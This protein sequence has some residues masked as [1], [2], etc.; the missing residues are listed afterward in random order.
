MFDWL[1]RNQPSMKERL[2][3]LSPGLKLEQLLDSEVSPGPGSL[4]EVEDSEPTYV[5]TIRQLLIDLPS[6]YPRL[7]GT[8]FHEKAEREYQVALRIQTN[9]NLRQLAV[10]EKQ[11]SLRQMDSLQGK[12]HVMEPGQI[13]RP[14]VPQ[15]Q[16]ES[17]ISAGSLG[18]DT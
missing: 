3:G 4:Q 2:N 11:T 6:F 12:R 17:E 18:K 15:P 16:T 10:P 8:R 14:S 7:V 9:R 5:E 1:K 13:Y